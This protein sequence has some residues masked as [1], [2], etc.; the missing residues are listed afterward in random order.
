MAFSFLLE[1]YPGWKRNSAKEWWTREMEK[2]L[3]ECI[4]QS[5]R[6]REYRYYANSKLCTL[7]HIVSF[8][9]TCFSQVN[10]YDKAVNQSLI[11]MSC[12]FTYYIYLFIYYYYQFIITWLIWCY[13]LPL[14]DYD[15]LFEA[16]LFNFQ[17]LNF[18]TFIFFHRSIK[19][20]FNRKIS[21]SY[22][23]K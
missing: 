9:V 3:N 14:S 8:Y 4:W 16:I 18:D 12:L 10:S 21:N 6:F 23:K 11:K 17:E 5:Q 1:W 22:Y 7:I 20:I 15:I 19:E 13:V 2:S